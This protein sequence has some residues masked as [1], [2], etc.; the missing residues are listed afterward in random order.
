MKICLIGEYSGKL[1]EGMKNITFYLTRELSR[2][3][4][5]L[6][7]NPKAAFSP[8]FWRKARNFRPQIIHYIPGPSL[9][10]FILVK[11]LALNYGRAKVAM[12]AFHPV[13]SS[14]SQ[15]FIPL[16]K[17][18]I[19][20][21]Q[22]HRTEKMFSN[23]DCRTAF[24]PSGVDIDRFSPVSSEAKG[25]LR[26][27]YG[28]DQKRFIA[29]HVGH[30]N[31][32]RNLQV[33]EQLQGN[34][35]QVIIV[36]STST[37]VDRGVY[38]Q[39]EQKGCLVWRNYLD[40]IE[41]VYALADC[42]IFPTLEALNAVELPISVMEAMACNLPV[43]TTRFGALDRIFSEGD[44]LFFVETEAEF[45]DRLEQLKA[46]AIEIKTREKVLPYSWKSMA[47]RAE[48]IYADLYPAS[49]KGES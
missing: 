9:Q 3:N 45:G 27:Q 7:L 38:R 20:F 42:Y 34:G 40:N 44:G 39:L 10:S 23:L 24:L 36:G 46:G 15:K 14:F 33:M 30:L 5:V 26:E 32:G 18:D 35:N 37:G 13:I 47:T 12:S 6:N 2:R 11:A 31:K 48:E 25:K 21:I 19:V 1:D 8:G 41:E 49:D 22:S 4:E 17:P 43:V 28:I 29:L 16:L